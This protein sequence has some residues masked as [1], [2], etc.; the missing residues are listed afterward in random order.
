MNKILAD[1]DVQ[2]AE[3]A[4]LQSSSSEMT[5]KWTKRMDDVKKKVGTK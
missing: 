2:K 5:A 1:I 4:K 3:I